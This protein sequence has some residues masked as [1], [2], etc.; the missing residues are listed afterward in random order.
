MSSNSEVLHQLSN[1]IRQDSDADTIR[2]QYLA[3]L[4]KYCG[5]SSA[6]LVCGDSLNTSRYRT[7]IRKFLAS[8]E[9]VACEGKRLLLK[10]RHDTVILL[11]LERALDP[12]SEPFLLS[13]ATILSLFEHN[14]KLARATEASQQ[15]L[16]ELSDKS[17]ALAKN[18]AHLFQEFVSNQ[19]RLLSI[20]KGI[21][22][23]QEEERSKISRELHDGLG[24]ALTALKIHLEFISAQEMELAPESKKRLQEIKTLAEQSLEDVRELSRL[25]RPRILDDLGLYPTLRWYVRKFQKRTG[26]HVRL[27]LVGNGHRLNSEIETVLFR[28]TQEALNNIAKHSKAASATVRLTSAQK[29]IHL[30]I[31]DRGIGFPVKG[32]PSDSSQSGSGLSGIRDRVSLWGGTLS[33]QSESGKGTS[34][35]VKIPL[36]DTPKKKRTKN[37]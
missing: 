29:A 15:L 12:A 25:L 26:I 23:T 21:L 4:S 9:S 32:L 30:E 8:N 19:N 14:Q 2:K 3:I 11:N 34:I 33:V 18:N 27:A 20:S 37:G 13:I 1:V 24:Q 22:R 16:R 28:V 31:E 36:K 17:A 5:A 6:A 10:L 35:E 7:A